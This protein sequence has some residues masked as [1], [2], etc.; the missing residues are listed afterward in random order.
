MRK[1]QLGILLFFACA[2]VFAQAKKELSINEKEI[3]KLKNPANTVKI[4]PNL[5]AD[6]TEIPNIAYHEYCDWLKKVFGEKSNIYTAAAL[7]KTILAIELHYGEPYIETYSEHP[8]FDNYP[9]IGVSYEQAIAFSVWR[10]DRAYQMI[11]LKNKKIKPQ[12]VEALDSTNYFTTTRYLAGQYQGLKPDRSISIPRF[13]LPTEQEWELFA[14]GGGTDKS[15]LNYGVDIRKMLEK[16]KKRGY[17]IPYCELFNTLETNEMLSSQDM[18][19]TV[20]NFKP[21]DLGIYNVIGNVA[22]MTAEKGVAKGGSIL[23]KLEDCLIFKK[24]TYT[25]PNRWLGFRNV[26]TWEYP[27]TE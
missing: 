14:R 3:A 24:Q 10:T 5:F 22:E 4:S 16:L 13:R 26:C 1:Y 18:A 19:Q 8:A 23:H 6:K 15:H 11:L 12:P 27:A 2:N 7:D 25:T 20:T 9:L 21:N 17:N